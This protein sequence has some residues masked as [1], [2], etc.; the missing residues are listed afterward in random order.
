MKRTFHVGP[1]SKLLPAAAQQHRLGSRLFL[2]EDLGRASERNLRLQ[3]PGHGRCRQ[4]QRQP[5][6]PYRPRRHHRRESG[7]PGTG[8][9]SHRSWYG[10][11]R[12]RHLQLV[13]SK[14]SPEHPYTKERRRH[15]H[16]E[17]ATTGAA[18]AATV[19]AN[20]TTTSGSSTPPPPW[21]A[22][23]RYTATIN[24]GTAADRDIHQRAPAAASPPDPV[25]GPAAP[26]LMSTWPISKRDIVRVCGRR[27]CVSGKPRIGAGFP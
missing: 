12:E 9:C 24:G 5:H 19:T 21:T 18:V 20:G 6:R 10:H 2:T 15:L 17:S 4:R 23:T 27:L 7:I 25:I 1:G 14:R 3:R 8:L 16:P 22:S 13:L 11:Q 26:W